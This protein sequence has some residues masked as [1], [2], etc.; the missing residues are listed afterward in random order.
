MPP[1]NRFLAFCSILSHCNLNL[2]WLHL[3]SVARLGANC[4][5]GICRLEHTSVRLSQKQSLPV[6]CFLLYDCSGICCYGYWCT[7]CLYGRNV[8]ALEGEGCVAPCCFYYWL[9]SVAG[10]IPFACLQSLVAGPTR[11]KIRELHG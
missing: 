10:Y 1:A 3:L 6:V 8:N 7:S 5:F 4:S 9:Y 2:I 11:E